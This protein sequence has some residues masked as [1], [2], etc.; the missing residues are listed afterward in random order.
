MGRNIGKIARVKEIRIKNN[1][2]DWF[3][4]EIHEQIGLRDKLFA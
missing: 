4:E 1:W 2:Q 3:D